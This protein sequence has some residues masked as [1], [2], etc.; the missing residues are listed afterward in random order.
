MSVEQELR[1][2]TEFMRRQAQV[3]RINHLYGNSKG[4]GFAIGA[5]NIDNLTKEDWAEFH[6]IGMTEGGEKAMKFLR[7]KSKAMPVFM[8]VLLWF[9]GMVVV[10]LLYSWYLLTFYG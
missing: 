2:Q 6:R 8:P 10:S 1:K 9:L 4:K 7:K 3:Q 5:G